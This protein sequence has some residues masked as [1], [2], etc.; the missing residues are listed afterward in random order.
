M[1]ISAKCDYACRALLELSFHWPDKEPIAINEI[2]IKQN[3]PL[4][5]LVQI[6]ILLKSAG[7][8]NSVRGKHG[9][10][11]LLKPPSQITVRDVLKHVAGPLLP[12]ADS[13]RKKESIFLPIWNEIEDILAKGLEK[14]T[15][16]DIESRA[17]G[18][19][20]ALN[21]QI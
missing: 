5:Y 7:F 20:Q 21:Y 8:V 12:M 10:Y 19:K 9:G 13:A 18:E 16:E 2:A 6:L 15:F 4:K 14:I 3:I 17:K 11:V 1:R